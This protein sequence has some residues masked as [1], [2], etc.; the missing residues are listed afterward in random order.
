MKRILVIEDNLMIRDNA[1]ELL[2]LAG[3][4]VMTA[5]GGQEG[6]QLA[7]AQEFDA[8]LCD[9]MMPGVSGHDVFETLNRENLIGN[10]PFIFISASVERQAV[11][12]ALG[13]GVTAYIRKPFEEG[14]LLNTLQAH[15]GSR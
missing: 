15:L 7:R 13:K 12:E 14:E 11:A 8:F 4:Q 1:M 5:P 10:K 6:I 9:V 3:Y 2:E